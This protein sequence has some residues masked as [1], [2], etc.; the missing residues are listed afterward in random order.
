MT[1]GE[2]LKK[3]RI[4][5]NLSQKELGMMVGFSEST[6]DSRIRKYERNVMAPKADMLKKLADA[7]EIDITALSDFDIKTPD[8]VMHILFDLEEHHGMYLERSNGR[9]TFSFDETNEKNQKLIS[10][11]NVWCSQ[12]F[13]FPNVPLH[14]A[15]DDCYEE[16]EKWKARFPMELDEIM[17]Q[18]N[19]DFHEKYKSYVN[20][21]EK[22]ESTINTISDFVNL[23]RSIIQKGHFCHSV[24]DHRNNQP[25]LMICFKPEELLSADSNANCYE[26]AK[27]LFAL[28]TLNELG[29]KIESETLSLPSGDRIYYTLYNEDLA[30]CAQIINRVIH[31]EKFY[32]TFDE[33][34]LNMFEGRYSS[35]LQEINKELKEIID[36]N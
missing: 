11:L 21:I 31:H 28:K 36:N 25:V 18:Q 1:L 27:F 20:E 19:K 3:Q 24:I 8:E 2:K 15:N 22:Q 30:Q 26:F 34:T 32:E 33:R 35:G 4:L 29:I 23:V 16:Y 7:L 14:L 17:A 10:Y 6:A 12:R 13:Q 5:K 9:V